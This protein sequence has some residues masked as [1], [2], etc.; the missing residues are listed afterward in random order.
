MCLEVLERRNTNI[1]G[2]EEEEEETAEGEVTTEV[3]EEAL[4]RPFLSAA[5]EGRRG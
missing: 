2:G 1:S 3:E 4:P 5:E